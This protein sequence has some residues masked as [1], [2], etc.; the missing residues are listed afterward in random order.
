MRRRPETIVAVAAL[1]SLAFWPVQIG[2]AFGLPAHPLLIHVPV[3]FVPILG[4]ATL[5]VALHRGWFERAGVATAAF[6]AVTNAATLLAAGAGTAFRAEREDE[7]TDK[8]KLHDHADAGL[9]L[10]L[11]MVLL[12][13]TLVGLLF[14]TRGRIVLKVL[15]VLLALTAIVFV[16]RTGHLGSQLAWEDA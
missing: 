1:L 11:T 16:I 15:V 13:A 6:A 7:I 14:A 9:T 12:T 4:V 10:K 8:A 2:R 3:V 5:A